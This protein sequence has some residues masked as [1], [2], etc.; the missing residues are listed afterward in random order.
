M[1]HGRQRTV[2]IVAAEP[3]LRLGIAAAIAPSYEVVGY[4]GTIAEA[5]HLLS[6]R[7]PAIALLVLDPPL[8]DSM[9]DT[10]CTTLM[11][12]CPGLAA[13]VLLREVTAAAVRTACLAGARGVLGLDAP[14]ERLHDAIERVLEGQLVV[15]AWVGPQLF[16]DAAALDDTDEALT[17]NQRLVLQRV[18]DGQTSKEI[19]VTLGSTSTAV[20][21][22][23][24]RVAQ[25]LNAAHRAHAVATGLR[26]GLID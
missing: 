5:A 9:P 19:A 10:A 4:A 24:E 23:I 26:L 7:T 2:A 1:V 22:R 25:R 18:A 15:D 16:T 17:P 21:R 14:V 6:Q 20:D 13:L 8:P 12:R 3:M 11:R